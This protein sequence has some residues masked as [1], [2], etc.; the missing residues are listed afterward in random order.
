M[1]RRMWLRAGAGMT[2]LLVAAGAAL[3]QDQGGRGGPPDPARMAERQ[4]TMLKERLK[5]T[6]DQVLKVKPILLDMAKKSA[7]MREKLGPPQQ[8][9]RPSE[10]MMAE[11]RKN[12][13]DMDKKLA[14]VFTDDQKKEYEKMRSQ[15]RGPGGFGGPRGERKGPPQQ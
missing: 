7:E 4:L 9:Q 5:L 11:M 2:V 13:E 3:A 15:R 6:D 14:E 8:G 10:E 12:R 1:N